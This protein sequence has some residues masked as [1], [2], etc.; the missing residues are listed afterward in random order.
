MMK[1]AELYINGK[2]KEY[3]LA[4]LKLDTVITHA[5]RL[6]DHTNSYSHFQTFLCSVEHNY[7]V[8]WLWWIISLFSD[9][10]YI[11]LYFLMKFV[12]FH[13]DLRILFPC[14]EIAF[15]QFVTLCTKSMETK[16]KKNCHHNVFQIISKCQAEI[17][18]KVY[19][20]KYWY[21][22]Y[23]KIVKTTHHNQ[24]TMELCSTEHRRSENE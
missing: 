16:T 10:R 2:G 9:K 21:V 5:W 7:M 23:Q 13:P 8:H 19:Q 4:Q 15:S 17:P 18:R 1:Y 12:V 20:I 3:S 14:K 24:W 22:L 6:I 11:V